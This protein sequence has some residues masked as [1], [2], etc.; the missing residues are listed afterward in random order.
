MDNHNFELRL[1]MKPGVAQGEIRFA[2]VHRLCDTL[3]DL[4]TKI[5]RLVT[6]QEGP[7][8]SPEATARVAELRLASVR[9]GSTR[10]GVR[11]GETNPLP[12]AEFSQVED[13]THA[14]FQEIVQGLRDQKC[15]DWVTPGIAEST[16]QVLDAFDRAAVSVI[17]EAVDGWSVGIIPMHASRT[18][19]QDVMRAAAT[20][21]Q[22]TVTGLL[23]SVNLETRHFRI[24]DDVGNIIGLEDVQNIDVASELIGKRATAA[25]L[26]IYGSNGEL[27]T[28]RLPLVEARVTP[29]R[30][31]AKRQ[32]D[33]LADE[34]A[35]PGPDPRG[36]EG[37]TS[38]DVDEFLALIRG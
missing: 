14:K 35:K 26:A 34:L 19:W 2:D 31:A 11:Y 30:W 21:Q 13:E 1:E 7:G 38:E 36:V 9:G 18:P 22:V 27:R 20:D 12:A 23:Y 33:S 29:E 28:V 6:E 24:R 32:R 5:S 3:Q 10:L 25:G 37:I 8:R 15:P 17:I 16:L 4:N